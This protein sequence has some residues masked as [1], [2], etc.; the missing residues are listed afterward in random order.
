MDRLEQMVLADHVIMEGRCA[1]SKDPVPFQQ[2]RDL[3]YQVIQEGDEWGQTWDSAWFHLS[4]K[5]PKDW[6]NDEVVAHLD[7]N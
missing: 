3:E 7:F 6:T 5:I 2:R 1:R 4:G